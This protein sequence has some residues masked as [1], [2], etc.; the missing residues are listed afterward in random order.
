[1]GAPPADG[2][3]DG[4]LDADDNCPQHF[5]DDQADGDEDGVGDACDNCPE[6]ANPAQDNACGGDFGNAML[7][8][9]FGM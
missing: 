6:I 5:N 3:E 2:D 4:V 7:P 1:M 9:D 8:P